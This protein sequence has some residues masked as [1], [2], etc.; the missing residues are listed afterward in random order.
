[1]ADFLFAL[2][3]LFRYL[4]RFRGYEAKCVQL[5]CFCRVVDRFALKFYLDRVLPQQPLLAS[6]N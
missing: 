6:E 4:L 1:M 3:E 2:I 5:G